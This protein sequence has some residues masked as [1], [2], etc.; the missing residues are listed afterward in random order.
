MPVMMQMPCACNVLLLGLIALH[1]TKGRPTLCLSLSGQTAACSSTKQYAG[2]YLH[3]A[4]IGMREEY[5]M[6]FFL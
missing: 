3:F 1:G 5:V 6:W 4:L 2:G